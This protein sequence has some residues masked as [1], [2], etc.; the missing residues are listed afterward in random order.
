MNKIVLAATTFLAL[1]ALLLFTLE[2]ASRDASAA[3]QPAPTPVNVAYS[4]GA[5]GVLTFFGSARITTDTNGP[6]VGVSEYEKIDLQYVIDQ[7]A[8]P[9][10]V[11]LS[12]QYSND[13]TNW[14]P[15]L[16]IV[17]GNAAD[18]TAMQQFPLYGQFA[19][20]RADVALTQP[21]TITIPGLA[22]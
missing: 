20:V 7:G 5:G 11:T 18:A 12:I 21:V 9:N 3:P 8:T 16:T 6:I 14:D 10:T 4:T 2:S 15:G 17:S 22:K 1:V 19:R 13:G